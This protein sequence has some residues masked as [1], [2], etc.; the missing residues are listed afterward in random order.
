MPQQPES[1]AEPADLTQSEAGQE[2][3]APK[4]LNMSVEI[5][6]AGTCRKH[7]RVVIDRSDID[8]R[9]EEKYRELVKD[10][11]VP[12]YRPG[13]A[14]RRLVEK[15]YAKEVADQVKSELL[16]QSL[17]QLTEDDRLQPISQPQFDPT[18]VELPAQ[19]PLVYE[20]EVE[21][22]PEFDLPEYKGLRLK[23]PVR[24]ITE[25]DVD[26]ALQRLLRSRGQPVR[27]AGPAALGDL[28]VAD[29]VFIADGKELNRARQVQVR[30]DPQ[31]AFKDGLI[32]DFGEKMA[33]IEA[34]QTRSVDLVLAQTLSDPH[35]RGRTIEARFHVHE[36]RQLQPADLN[37]EFLQRAGVSS[38]EE[39]RQVL[40]RALELEVEQQQ[41]KAARQQ[42]TEY[43]IANAGWDLPPDLVARQARKTLQR[44]VLE[45]QSAGYS[46]QEIRSRLVLLQQNALQ[47]TQRALKEQFVLHK[48]AEVEKLD[49]DEE[50]VAREIERIAD[51]TGE[52]P[53]RVR[54]RIEKEDLMEP[55]MTQILEAKALDL[56]LQHAVYEDVAYRPEEETEVV[57]EQAVPG[58]TTELPEEAPPQAAAEAP[59]Q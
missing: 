12:G 27:K 23:R 43:L 42:V 28:L 50:D 13:K 1:Q 20:F 56:V 54:A 58:A 57:E 17:E 2:E 39:L 21:V 38:K 40:R 26:Q 11:F 37:E 51:Q 30:L 48:I 6:D 31:L 15:R 18:R 8:Q 4:R 36:V 47:V 49:V 59:A 45:L 41:R 44:M 25:A 22:V 53:R 9:L 24:T 19:G 46:E 5:R 3:S 35:L 10:A 52:S 34:G 14:P 32:A 7:V 33:G 16:L 29:I 55:L